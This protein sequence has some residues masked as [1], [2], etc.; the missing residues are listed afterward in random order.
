MILGGNILGCILEKVFEKSID[1]IKKI[2]VLFCK[3]FCQKIAKKCHFQS[4]P[5]PF[6]SP[7]ITLKQWLQVP[8]HYI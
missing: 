2:F 6:T 1:F 8:L 5:S 3:G 4:L 7:F